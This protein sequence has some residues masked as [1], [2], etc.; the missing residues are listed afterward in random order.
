[1]GRLTLITGGAR[2]GKST[3]AEQLLDSRYS[4]V[5]YI[6]TARILDDEMGDRVARHK[7]QRPADWQTFEEPLQPSRIVSREGNQFDA[8]LLDCLTVLTTNIILQDAAVGWDK[9]DIAL[10]NLLEQEVMREI[11]NL[12]K[13]VSVFSGHLVAVTNEVGLGIVPADPLS[14]FFRDCSGRVNQSMAAAAEAVLF[15]VAGIPMQVKGP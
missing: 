12:I 2:S 15:V 10:L 3:Y 8:I 14:R 13:A 9:P 7:R 1:M 5:A 4:S 11:D 6:A